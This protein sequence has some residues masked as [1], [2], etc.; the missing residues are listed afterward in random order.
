MLKRIVI[1]ILI[2]FLLTS[3]N[4]PFQQIADPMTVE[5]IVAMTLT[6]ELPAQAEQTPEPV[7]VSPTTDEQPASATMTATIS[8]TET[9]TTT[10]SDTPTPT[11]TVPPAGI[12]DTLGA[13][14]WKNTLDDGNAF[15]LEG[16]GYEDDNTRIYIENGAM[17]LSSS[18]IYGYRGW[19]LTVE[20]PDN[21]YLEARVNVQSCSGSDMYG[22]VFRAPDYGSGQ[23]YYLGITC[24][25]GYNVTK[26]TASGTST[27]LPTTPTTFLQ[28]GAGQ[29]HDIG[30]HMVGTNFTIYINNS[31][32]TQ[33][34][35]ASFSEGGHFGVFI[36]GQ[37]PDAFL[38]R[39]EEMAYWNLE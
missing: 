14:A 18:S 11:E 37:S 17:V 12:K 21:I 8:I 15:G 2:S 27:V 9:H 36:A 35:D 33:F 23:G 1:F 10:P 5:E 34:S 38:V 26:W 6:A 13:P 28:P 24:E 16:A 7:V 4:F 29:T 30:I 39:V 20:S 19:R 31:M 25:G 3:C 32:V 22:L